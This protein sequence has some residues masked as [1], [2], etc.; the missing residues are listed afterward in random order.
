MPV[1]SHKRAYGGARMSPQRRAVADTIERLG[2]AFTIDELAEEVR[3]RRRV[4]KATIYRAVAALEGSGWV[5]R[6]GTQDGH[7]LF[8]RCD[9][10]DHHHH[11][12]C[13]GCGKVAVTRCLLDER[14]MEAAARA[15][16]QVTEHEITLYGLCRQCDE[17]SSSKGI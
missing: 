9:R 4:G 3:R 16:F 6:V 17:Q 8:A 12:V 15:G 13:T 14:A 11:L 2:R 7:S 1:R 10:S 5:A